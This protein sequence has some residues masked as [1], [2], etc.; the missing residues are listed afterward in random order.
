MPLERRSSKPNDSPNPAQ[1]TPGPPTADAVA[2]IVTDPDRLTQPIANEHP[3]RLP[4]IVVGMGASAGGLEAYSEFFRVMPPKSGMAFILIQ[5]LPPQRESMMVEILSKK[6]AMLVHQIED[7]MQIEPNN[8]YVIRPG[9]TL[10]LK[11]GRLHLGDPL[12]KP[13]HR[14]PVDDFFRSLAAEQQERAIAVVLSGMGS[15][16]SAGAQAIKAVGGMCIAQDPDSCHYSSMPRNLIDTGL[17]D[18]VLR[19]HEIPEVL[20]RYKDHP[21]VSG[22]Q[23]ATRVFEPESQSFHELLA[24]LRIRTRHDFSGYKKSTLLRR[25]QRRMGLT[26]LTRLADYVRVLRQNAAEVSALADDLMI[27]VTGFF[28]DPEAWEALR[29]KVI[30]P[31]V[32]GRESGTAIR[33]W[34]A[35]CSSGEE[36]YT[37]GMLLLEAAAHADKQ[38]DIKIFATDMAVRSLGL[39][40]A[41]TYPAGI[42]SEIR[43]DRLETFFERDDSIYR[44]RKELRELVIF[45]PQNI[46]QD[47][48]FSRLDICS[49]RNLLIYL[50]P[51][52]QRRVIAMLHFGLHE[53]GTMF[54]GTAET[55]TGLEDLFEPLNKKWRIFRRSGATRRSGLEFSHLSRADAPIAIEGAPP[56]VLSRSSLVNLTQRVLLERFSPASVLIDRHH[57]VLY[58]HGNTNAFLN[59]PAGEPTRDVLDLARDFVRGPVRAA[60]HQCVTQNET[61]V[62]R[63]ALREDGDQRL[64]IEVTAQPLE[65]AEVPTYFLISFRE[66][67]ES[68]VHPRAAGDALKPEVELQEELQRTREELQSTIE[69]FQTNHEELKA[70]NEEIIS[71]NE[72]LQSTDEELE[73]S[74]EELQSLNEELTTVNSQLQ[75]KMEEAEGATNDLTSLLSSTDIAVLFLDLQLR[76]RRYTP[77][78]RDLVDLIPSDVGRPLADL[79]QKFTDPNLLADVRSVLEH[80]APIER[81]LASHSGN[82]YLRRILPY[83]TGDNRIDGVVVTFVNVTDRRSIESELRA[84]KQMAD[85]ARRLAESANITK[86]EFLATISHE[87]RNPLN[88]VVMW[89]HLLLR[90]TVAPAEL[91]EAYE[92]IHRN[93]QAQ[94]HLI[95]DLI[96]TSRIAAGKLVL[97]FRNI[98]LRT[99]ANAAVESIRPGCHEKGVLLRAEFGAEPLPVRVDPERIQQ[100]FGNLLSNALKFT[101]PKNEISLVCSLDNGLAQFA[102]C[103]TGHGISKELLPEIF[104]PFRQDRDSSWA[105]SGLGLGLAIARKLVEA[106]GGTIVAHSDGEGCGATFTVRLPLSSGQLAENDGAMDADSNSAGRALLGGRHVLLLEDDLDTRG[107]L[108]KLLSGYSATVSAAASVASAL[109]IYDE[110][111]VD[112]ILSDIMMPGEDGVAFIRQVRARERK[113]RSRHVPA[114]ALTAVARSADAEKL[115]HEGFQDHVTKPFDVRTLLKAIERILGPAPAKTDAAPTSSPAA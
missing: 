23:D 53:A 52:M 69:E 96:E 9:Y 10:T 68:P 72:E 101:P 47:P 115:V 63:S 73:T 54:L 51:E 24:V 12:E 48:P 86:D 50:E 81:E 27:H 44:I 61:A 114:I 1:S 110:S 79:A 83:R 49:C 90:G 39:A 8:V 74:K 35:A 7:G 105:Q 95:D 33:C 2:D 60:L 57:R 59:Q 65:P 58:F 29:E 91:K 26:Q 15:N 16:G 20:L 64:R 66:V 36:A 67:L 77:A 17:A 82:W 25:V 92:A 34:V 31:L 106:H 113:S 3:P 80:L 11:D 42:E 78:I 97:H 94:R 89:S 100:I 41:G 14:R 46:L 112:L 98:D 108:S 19:P 30:V 76:I 103:D 45:A 99:I 107:A 93:A 70:S 109:N 22:E 37:L 6:T 111:S 4:F 18:F 102:V 84:A 32:A 75:T 40:R 87:L 62:A 56:R 88:A 13:G 5:H 104:A 55:I 43:P 28:R 38:F 85:T 21:Y 71:I